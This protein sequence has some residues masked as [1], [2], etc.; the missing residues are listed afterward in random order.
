MAN[1]LI[2]QMR[3]SY[4]SG[5]TDG[6]SLYSF[7]F[8]RR[9]LRGQTH[10]HLDTRASQQHS[11]DVI[12]GL[13]PARCGTGG[14]DWNGVPIAG[15]PQ[16]DFPL[17]IGSAGRSLATIVSIFTYCLLRSESITA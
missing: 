10:G 4:G 12:H 17:G 11:G 15:G 14:R 3:C 5:N 1:T 6:E 9:L 7:A 2:R 13:L 16:P 8:K